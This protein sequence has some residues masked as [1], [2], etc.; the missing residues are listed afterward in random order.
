MRIIGIQ[1]GHNAA[2]CLYED[3]VIRLALQEE[4]LTRVKNHDVF[5]AHAIAWIL[6]EAGMR[7]EDLNGAA[8]NGLHQP[9]HRD[10]AAL[11][12]ATRWG[13]SMAP[14]RVLRRW[15]RATPLLQVWRRKH[16]HTRLAEA[17]AAGLPAEKVH[18]IEHHRCHAEAAYWGSP[19]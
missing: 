8:L 17:A 16:R 13:G 7:A 12:E 14:D 5:P 6:R 11:I 9:V 4:R 3:G 19:F 15:A 10:R 1:D 18:F 2:A